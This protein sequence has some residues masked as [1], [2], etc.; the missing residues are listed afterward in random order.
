MKTPVSPKVTAAALA[1]L[2]ASILLPNVGL[3]TP[4]MLSALGSWAPFWY[5]VGVTAISTLA[6]FIKNDPLRKPD[7]R[8]EAGA[9]VPSDTA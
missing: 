2:V 4:E 7:G 5:G 9:E 1:G 8:H 3:V 6:A